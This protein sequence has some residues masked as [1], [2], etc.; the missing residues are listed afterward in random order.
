MNFGIDGLQPADKFFLT[1]RGYDERHSAFQNVPVGESYCQAPGKRCCRGRQDT[2]GLPDVFDFPDRVCRRTK[3]CVDNQVVA[4][5]PVINAQKRDQDEYQ[6]R[7]TDDNGP[8]SVI[9]K[10]WDDAAGRDKSNDEPCRSVPS[11]VIPEAS[12]AVH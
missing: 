5:N 1:Y 11:G 12:S 3:E 6:H 9:H 10:A 7:Q 8:D 2:V 4:I